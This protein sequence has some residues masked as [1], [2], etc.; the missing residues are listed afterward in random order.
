MF[1]IYPQFTALDMV[2]P[3]H[4]LTSLMGA[5]VHLVSRTRDPVQCDTGLSVVPSITFDECPTDLDIICVPGGSRG[6]LA[7]MEDEATMRFLKD[8]RAQGEVRHVG[9]HRFAAPGCGGVARRIQGDVALGHQGTVAVSLARLPRRGGRRR[10][11]QDHR[12]RRDGGDRFRP[13]L[14]RLRDRQYAEGVQLMAEYDPKPPYLAQAHP[15]ARPRR[16]PR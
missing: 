9:L 6:T 8:P 14:G 11:Q 2:G 12:R 4:M 15:S 1:L 16:S 10:P 5:T 13:D 7:A 3:H